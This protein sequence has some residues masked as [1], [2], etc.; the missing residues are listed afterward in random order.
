MGGAQRMR[1]ARAVCVTL[2]C[3]LLADCGHGDAF[4]APDFGSADSYYS[5]TPVRLTLNAG[6]DLW[7]TWLP[8]G[9]G[10]LYTSERLDRPD[11]DWC[12]VILPPGGGRITRTICENTKVGEDSVQTFQSAAVS[13]DGRL[14]Y[15]RSSG[16]AGELDATGNRARSRSLVLGSLTAPLSVRTLSSIGFTI[17]GVRTFGGL[18]QISWLDTSTIVYRGDFLGQ[19]CLVQV[20]KCPEAFV[21][22]G[23]GIIVHTL[24]DAPSRVLLPGTDYVS[25]VAVGASSDELFFTLGGDAR[26]YRYT[27]STGTI[28]VIYD[29]GAAGIA[30]DIQVRGSKLVAVV[31]GPTVSFGLNASVNTNLQI[32]TIGGEIH[33]VDL[34]AGTDATISAGLFFRHLAL[35][36]AGDRLVAESVSGGLGDLWLFEVP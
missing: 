9:S 31:G 25:S 19:V 1:R 20:P 13:A 16:R 23:L 18:S 14:I 6:T 33:V 34:L 17:P 36:P 8:D 12:L 11:R 10:I 21:Q 5:G 3:A 22:S 29:F 2:W 32:D 4:R 7:P 28:T 35:S 15:A 27:I 26:V 30:R 24:G